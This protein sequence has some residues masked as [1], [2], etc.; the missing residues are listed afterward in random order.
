V[1]LPTISSL[2]VALLMLVATPVVYRL[3]VIVYRLYLHPLSG[4]PGPKRDA[5]TTL[6]RA[7]YQVYR[8]G[9]HVEQF[10]KLHAQYGDSPL[11]K[12][13]I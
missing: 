4:F 13:I 8:D 2:A 6:Y 10:T 11:A 5:A 1:P 3:L 12:F 9:G 7:Y